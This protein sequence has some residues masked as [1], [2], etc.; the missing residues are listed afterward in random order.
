MPRTGPAGAARGP[1]CH[2]PHAPQHLATV[3]RWTCGRAHLRG[4]VCCA[5]GARRRQWG[6][7]HGRR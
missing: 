7:C 1:G 4:C 6:D 2:R 5:V 3:P